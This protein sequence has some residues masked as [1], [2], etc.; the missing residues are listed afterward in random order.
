M[1]KVNLWGQLPQIDKIR[2]PTEVLREQASALGDMT[3]GTL[4]GEVTVSPRE[5]SFNVDL[6]IVAPALDNY[7]FNVLEASHDLNLYPVKVRPGW[8][9]YDAKGQVDCADE[10]QLLG[11][12]EKVLTSPKVR[13]V[14][15]TLLAQ[16]RAM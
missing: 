14:V 7:R 11:A 16:S 8:N 9:K 4:Q 10:S 13:S 2:T 5:G 15:T 3:S 12:L 6:D 1:P